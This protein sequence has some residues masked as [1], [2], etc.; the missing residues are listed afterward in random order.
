LIN[1]VFIF[2]YVFLIII[3]SIV[4]K[5]VFPNNKEL[6]RKI[7][8]IGIGPLIPLAKYLEIEFSLAQYIAGGIS[9]LILINYIFKLIPTIEDI[10][11][12]SFGTLFYCLSLFILITFYWDK[13]PWALTAGY[14]IMA[15]GDGF[16]GLLGKN[17]KSKSWII[18]NQKK[19]L[20]GTSAMFFFSF[21]ILIILGA[22]GK[23]DFNFYYFLIALIS[24]ALE[25]ISILGLDNL[26]VPITAAYTFNLFVTKL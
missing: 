20:L 13:D 18:F 4:L 14:F 5:K 22:T 17:F 21:L 11:R 10:D 16:A 2:S 7:I 12:K 15:F 8:H 1:I 24:T 25:Q 26:S 3:L 9:I 6:F 23:F 19:S